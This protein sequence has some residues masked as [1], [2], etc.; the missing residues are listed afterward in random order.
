MTICRTG[1]VII[2]RI[3]VISSF[4]FFQAEDGIRDR[5]VTGVQSVLFRSNSNI[6]NSIAESSL[7]CNSP[8]CGDS[9]QN[10]I[11]PFF[12]LDSSGIWFGRL[13]DENYPPAAYPHLELEDP[14]SE[15]RAR[16]EESLLEHFGDAPFENSIQDYDF[17]PRKGSV[18]IDGGVVVP[19]INDGQDIDLNHPPLYSGQNRAFVGDA[20]DVG[21]YEYG[22][23]VY[24]IPGY[25]YSYPSV[26]KIGRAH[27]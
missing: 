11:D 14:W 24:W 7:E 2:T 13:L 20:P 1:P 22:D 26:P 6:H 10:E 25:R 16:S 3:L 5:L 19:G 9:T 27:V 23:S 21:A 4:F 15:N 18:L 8:D 17:R 12:L